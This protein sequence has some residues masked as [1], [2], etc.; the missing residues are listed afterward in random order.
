MEVMKNQLMG[1]GFPEMQRVATWTGNHGLPF[2]I[3]IDQ[4]TFIH[5]VPEQL[6]VLL[7][8]YAL[9]RRGV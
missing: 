3:Y 5:P 2:D 4:E 8:L 1:A 7:S 6:P 9:L